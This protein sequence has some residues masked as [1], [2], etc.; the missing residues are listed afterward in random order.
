[1]V[2]SPAI[3]SVTGAQGGIW[4]GIMMVVVLTELLIVH[5]EEC[6]S[7][8]SGVKSRERDK[9]PNQPI[10]D[11]EEIPPERL[12]QRRA[13]FSDLMMSGSG[14]H[15]INRGVRD[16]PKTEEYLVRWFLLM[17]APCSITQEAET[18]HNAQE[19][20]EQI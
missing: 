18:R 15:F 17:N 16:H 10:E 9:I 1:V 4:A 11:Y 19:A 7:D 12:H 14:T 2:K 8:L 20:A 3:V 5:N 13:R 6:N